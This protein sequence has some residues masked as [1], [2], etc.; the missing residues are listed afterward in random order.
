M[1]CHVDASGERVGETALGDPEPNSPSTRTRDAAQPMAAA[2]GAGAV[3]RP[4]WGEF[5]CAGTSAVL[6]I[7]VTNPVDVVKTRMVVQGQLGQGAS[8]YTS[9]PSALVQ[10]GRAEG[11]RGLQRGLGP[12]CLW[13]FS[14]VSVRFG[15]YGYAKRR[16]SPSPP[17]PAAQQRISTRAARATTVHPTDGPSGAGS[18][19]SASQHVH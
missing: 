15:V 9:V 16:I 2:D 18:G 12:S 11:L 7:C 19:L 10:I 3:A 6:A 14:N 17:P 4:W 13:Q 1:F 8:P 5:L